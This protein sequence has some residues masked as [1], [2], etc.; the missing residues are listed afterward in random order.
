MTFR[1]SLQLLRR[2]LPV[3]VAALVLGVA[4]GWVTAPGEAR[5]NTTFRATHTLIYAPQGNQSYNISQV[6]LLATSGA[7]PSR[8][9]TRLQVNREQVRSAVSAVADGQLATI[10]ITGRSSESARA[11]ALADVTAEEL[12]VEIDGG[13][14]AAYQ[15]E[16]G[17]LTTE[18]ESARDGLN[19]TKI[20]ADQ[21][22]ARDAVKIAADQAAARDAVAAAERRLEDFRSAD[23]PKSQLQPLEPAVASAVEPEGVQ[24]PNSK[25][26]RALLV[27]G[28]GLLVGAAAAFALDRLDSRIR[29]KRGA[30]EAFGAP[31]V[32]EVPPIPKSSQ[33]EL[34][35]LTQPSSPFVEAYRGLR[36]YVALWAPEVGEDDGHRVIV[37]TSPGAGEGKTT[38]VAHLASML[39]EI[40][41]SVIVVSADLRRPRLHEY[42]DRPGAP[43]LVDILADAPGAPAFRD[44][45][46]TTLVRGVRFVPSGPPVEN[47]AP[48]LEHAGEV[49][50]TVRR[51]A[52]FVL[53]D[54][55][56]LLIAND[57]V[58][59]ARHADGVLLVARAGKTP[60]EAAQRSAEQ[61]QRLEIPVVGAVLVGSETASTRSRYY[62]DRY[63]TEPDRTSFL[64]RR[65]GD[66]NG[67]GPAP[68]APPPPLKS[69]LAPV[70][71]PTAPVKMPHVA[72]TGRRQAA[73]TINGRKGN[74]RR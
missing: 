3:L 39:A 63:Y 72:R 9:A 16:L 55:P 23:P 14:Q 21:A 54:T 10:S 43:G 13:V 51:L 33:G 56:P 11:V 61:L 34:L 41:R 8:V 44:L 40:G 52:D 19:A 12:A 65:P 4:A 18:V 5:Q 7:V 66:G 32:A 64:R 45:D 24:A 68:E 26:G 37:V 71:A 59:F 53:V 48:L 6:A 31:V 20:A 1:D 57:A 22:A 35:A 38:T 28:V 30:E 73:G 50:R 58:E 67:E 36:T 27:G 70:K 25:P 69:T 74:R 29:S 47:P 62:R 17:R 15:A 49:L 46:L 60:I 2:R 42:F